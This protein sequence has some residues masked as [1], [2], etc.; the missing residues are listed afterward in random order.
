M[1]GGPAFAVSLV[2][3]AIEPMLWQ[4]AELGA[5]Q[6]RKWDLF[7]VNRRPHNYMALQLNT[8]LHFL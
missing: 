3:S 4:L 7:D 5:R 2:I 8:K 1:R 6:V